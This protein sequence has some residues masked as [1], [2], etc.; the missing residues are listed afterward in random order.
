M[1]LAQQANDTSSLTH[2]NRFHL[3]DISRSRLPGV[4]PIREHYFCLV[5]LDQLY[6]IAFGKCHHVSPKLVPVS[7]L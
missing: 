6:D 4:Q 7:G 5:N 3:R 2:R 1:W